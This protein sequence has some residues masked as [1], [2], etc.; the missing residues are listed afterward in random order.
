VLIL[1][2]AHESAQPALLAPM[3][4]KLAGERLAPLGDV[5]GNQRERLVGEIDPCTNEP[6]DR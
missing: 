4:G 1:P 5:A 6:M 2:A 3:L